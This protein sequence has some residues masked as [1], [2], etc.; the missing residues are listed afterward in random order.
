MYDSRTEVFYL[1]IIRKY[2]TSG[3]TC[4]SGSRDRYFRTTQ[5]WGSSQW[6]GYLF[7]FYDLRTV[8]TCT[9][10]QLHTYT[11]TRYTVRV[12]QNLF[13][14]VRKYVQNCSIRQICS[15]VQQGYTIQ[16]GIK[17]VVQYR[18]VVVYEGTFEGTEVLP[19]VLLYFRPG[20][21]YGDRIDQLASQ[22]ATF[23]GTGSQLD[24]LATTLGCSLNRY[25]YVYQLGLVLYDARVSYQLAIRT[26]ETKALFGPRFR[27]EKC[28]GA[29]ARARV[30]SL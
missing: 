18:V 27:P 30:T 9:R 22:L 16:P 11:R 21:S 10:A 14:V 12:Q 5:W 6:W 2:H 15:Y 19:E 24:Q 13:C 8:C 28:A 20:S 26:S 25:S 1:R 7:I 4:T 29:Q 23:E 3:S 17:S